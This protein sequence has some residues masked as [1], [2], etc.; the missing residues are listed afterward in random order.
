MKYALIGWNDN[1]QKRGAYTEAETLANHYKDKTTIF[2]ANSNIN[3]DK[4]RN[5]YDR[6]IYT[7]QNPNNLRTKKKLNLKY[8]NTDIQYIRY[9]IPT[10]YKYKTTNGFS[11]YLEHPLFVN[12]VPMMI[13]MFEVDKETNYDNIVLGYYIRP[14]YRPDDFR[15]FKSF[16]DNLK[17]DV[18][19]YVMGSF[20]YPFNQYK[21]VKK[22]VYTKDNLRF[23]KNITHYVY[24][25]SNTHDPY[26][27]TLQEAVN[28]N[29]QIVILKQNRKFKDGI[30][31]IEECI[32]YHIELSNKLIYDNSNSIL[33]KWNYDN[34]Y[35]KVFDNNF[36]YTFDRSKYTS[37]RDWL[38][39]W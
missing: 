5:E 19:L 20:I 32:D 24:S 9:N 27:T 25:E 36:E 2:N 6:I 14:E 1:N 35:N 29:K 10:T 26:P 7:Y 23:Y 4:L 34:F 3:I 39:Q 38:E 18:T 37:M 28:C 30:D 21:H 8:S 17:Y 13:P 31:D 22:L 11:M 33:N 16:L 12:Y 15:M